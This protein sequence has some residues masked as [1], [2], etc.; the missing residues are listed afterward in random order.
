MYVIW[1]CQHTL[2]VTCTIVDTIA[3]HEMS[4]YG[5]FWAQIKVRQGVRAP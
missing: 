2:A 1:A 4:V 5:H 3:S